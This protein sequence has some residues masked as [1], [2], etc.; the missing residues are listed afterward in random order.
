ML[1]LGIL[2]LLIVSASADTNIYVEKKDF[3][4]SVAQAKKV[5]LPAQVRGAVD[6]N[7]FVAHDSDFFLVKSDRPILANLELTS[8]LKAMFQRR[9]R[10]EFQ[11]CNLRGQKCARVPSQKCEGGVIGL[12][13]AVC[14]P[15]G[16]YLVKVFPD[17]ELADKFSEKHG[18]FVTGGLR[19]AEGI[20]GWV[21][22][23][24]LLTLQAD[25]Y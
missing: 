18:K 17:S 10:F 13:W 14:Y 12:R 1:A 6:L 21:D 7:A 16:E 25:G 23:D 19:L 9:V 22:I 3:G 20:Q 11:K 24:Y 2:T 15:A 8:S 5:E 4:S